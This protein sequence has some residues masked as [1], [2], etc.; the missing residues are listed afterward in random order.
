MNPTITTDVLTDA[1]IEAPE[2]L[3]YAA[4]ILA[5]VDTYM[6][7]DA[8]AGLLELR[9]DITDRKVTPAQ[10]TERMRAAATDMLV[11]KERQA[12]AKAARQAAADITERTIAEQAGAIFDAI[13]P[14][15]DAAASVLAKSLE[16]VEHRGFKTGNEPKYVSIESPERDEAVA[17]LNQLRAVRRILAG[18]GYGPSRETCTW[19]SRPTSRKEAVNGNG[20]FVAGNHEPMIHLAEVGLSLSLNTDAEAEEAATITDK[21]KPTERL[22]RV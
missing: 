17:E 3:A 19:Y 11:S 1:G 7:A 14:R 22:A 21:K 4:E 2:A 13:K 8:H 20:A 18:A 5:T 9:A 12:A 16:P 15:F 6:H 10:V